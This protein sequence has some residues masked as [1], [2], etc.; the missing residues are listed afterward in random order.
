MAS[1]YSGAYIFLMKTLEV[2]WTSTWYMRLKRWTINIWSRN[3]EVGSGL[4]RYMTHEDQ[5]DTRGTTFSRTNIIITVRHRC[6]INL[7]LVFQINDLE[8]CC[9]Q[10]LDIISSINHMTVHQNACILNVKAGEKLIK[11]IIVKHGNTKKKNKIIEIDFH[12]IQIKGEDFDFNYI[13]CYI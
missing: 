9:A 5:Q 3:G 12:F 1:L 11:Q 7:W 13:Y 6:L 10:N 4:H 8:F 2:R